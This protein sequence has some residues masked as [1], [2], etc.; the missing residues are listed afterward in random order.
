MPPI[1]KKKNLK[2]T[3]HGAYPFYR[4]KQETDRPN[5]YGS[6]DPAYCGH[7]YSTSEDGSS[8]CTIQATHAC[9]PPISELFRYATDPWLDS[10]Y[11]HYKTS[12]QFYA[13][14]VYQDVYAPYLE[15]PNPPAPPSSPIEL[16]QVKKPV[17][18]WIPY[19]FHQRQFGIEACMDQLL[20]A[21]N[22][23]MR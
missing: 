23:Q 19:Y 5:R 13:P 14:S 10:S 22:K 8:L 16:G 3:R 11:G 15:K 4:V 18:P 7:S 20:E 12:D 9:L 2:D 1:Y 17:R 21:R 6:L